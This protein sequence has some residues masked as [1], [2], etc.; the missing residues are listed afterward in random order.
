MLSATMFANEPAKVA[1]PAGEFLFREND[2][3]DFLYV[4]L[5]GEA[6]ILVGER[7]VE[8]FGPGQ[9]VGEMAMI[10][11]APRSA[12]VQALK[13]CEFARIDEKRFHFLVTETPGF[14]IAVMRIMAERLSGADRV[15]E[16][17]DEA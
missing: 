5:S 9:V 8:L 3:A 17:R 1:V 6:R 15:I 10:A 12:S 13:D 4:L 7:Q 16:S 2:A 11:S 14:A